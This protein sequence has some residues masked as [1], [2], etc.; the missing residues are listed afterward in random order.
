MAGVIGRQSGSP[1]AFGSL[2][3]GIRDDMVRVEELLRSQLRS[4]DPY[5]D[6]LVKHGFRLGGKRL[7]PA[8][9]LLAGVAVGSIGSAHIT[10]AVVMEM[11]HTATLI[12]DDVLDEAA[13]RRHLDTVNARWGNKSGVLLGDFLF[14]HAFYLAATTDDA[15]ACRLIGRSTNIV[16][17]GE[18][19]Q[20]NSRGRLDLPE[21]EYYEIID[22]K[23][24]EL[25]ACCCRLGAHF[26]GATAAQ[27]DAL[28]RYGRNLGIAFQIV[29]DLLD[30]EGDE[31]VTGKSLGT[32]LEQLKPTLP[33]IRLLN[34]LSPPDRGALQT[35]LTSATAER[36]A[37]LEPWLAR[38]DGL[39]YARNEAR[40]FAA[41]AQQDLEEIPPGPHRDV[42]HRL[43]E[44]VVSRN[45]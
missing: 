12:H 28:E 40:K 24:A 2:F 33:L 37:I 45:V 15:Y 8:L 43:A 18:M 13:L 14:S 32:D 17:E 5:V 22:A 30:L 19:R 31:A 38:T 23:T 25:C 41:M 16:C 1:R 7:R 42:L 29:D 35:A 20:I 21:S 4:A 6:Q 11:I 36:R 39:I 26:A 44:G 9:L 27:E 3:D 34:Q 10:L